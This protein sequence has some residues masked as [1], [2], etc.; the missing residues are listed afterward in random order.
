M[1]KFVQLNDLP[2]LNG[3]RSGADDAQ[4]ADENEL[5]GSDDED[6]AAP[7]SEMSDMV[8]GPRQRCQGPSA[9]GGMILQLG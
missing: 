7:A 9:V 4:P 1:H 6:Q 8:G 5:F 2:A 3:E